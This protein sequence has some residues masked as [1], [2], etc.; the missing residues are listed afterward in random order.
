[1][2]LFHMWTQKLVLRTSDSSF[3][4]ISSSICE[5]SVKFAPRNCHPI[6]FFLLDGGKLPFLVIFLGQRYWCIWF[7]TQKKIVNLIPFHRTEFSNSFC[8]RFFYPPFKTPKYA[9]LEPK[10]HFLQY[11]MFTASALCW[12]KQNK[13]IECTT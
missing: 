9:T 1:M 8:Q 12:F 4:S 6:L 7:H 11:N 2:T 5:K 3:C 13:Q 10:N